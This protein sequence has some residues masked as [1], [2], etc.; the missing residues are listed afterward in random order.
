M[1]FRIDWFDLLAFQGTL[2]ESSPAPQFETMSSS[3]LSLLD[4]LTLTSVYDYWKTIALTRQTS[5]GHVGLD[6]VF[7][8]LHAQLRFCL[9]SDV[10]LGGM[11][12]PVFIKS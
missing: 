5:V 6:P 8:I 9:P 4:G 3:A 11:I 2:K 1:L 7:S 12:S 10:P